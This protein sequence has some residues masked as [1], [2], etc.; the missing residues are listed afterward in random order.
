MVSGEIQLSL[1][2][3]REAVSCERARDPARTRRRWMMTLC[4][5]ALAYAAAV[6][7]LSV[8]SAD[9]GLFSYRGGPILSIEPD[10]PAAA[11]GLAVGDR[12][13]S[14]DGRAL[15]GPRE[16]ASALGGVVPGQTIRLGVAGPG[17]PA[18]IVVV[19]AARRMPWTSIAASVF[20]GFI[21]FLA[22]LADRGG[23]SS[24]P[25]QFFR[26]GLSISILLVGAFSWQVT[27]SHAALAMPWLI[28]LAMTPAVVCQFMMSHPVG[29]ERWARRQLAALY[30]PALVL[31]ALLGGFEL[32]LA[33]GARIP[34]HDRVL[35][36]LGGAAALTGAGYLS[37]GA[38]SRM[39]RVRR[40]RDRIARSAVRW[41]LASSICASVPI[42]VAFAWA[43]ID[44]PTLVGGAFRPL[45]AMAVVGGCT[46]AAMALVDV[47][48][49]EI[50]R[51]L[52]RRTGYVL[53][54]G[55][56]AGLF[57]I[58]VA[59][60]GGLVS[61]LSGGSF[62][63]ALAATFVA[64]FLFGPV[65]ERVQRTVDDRFGRDRERA[66][67]LLREAADAA[68]AT[69]DA[70]ELGERVVSRVRDAMSAEGAAIVA[71][72]GEGTWQRLAIGGAVPIG[73]PLPHGEPIAERLDRLATVGAPGTLCAD[74]LAVP[75][76]V[77]GA[78]AHALVVS[79]RAGG[80]LGSEDR[81]LLGTLA[82][83]L[84]AALANAHAHEALARMRDEAERRR[85]EI[86]RLKDL[87][88][89]ENRRLLR[90]L[91]SHGQ[92]EVIVGS[93]L[94]AT[95][96][97]VRRAART[98]S[99]VLV[100]GE[101]GCGKEVVAR[102]L[103][104]A[105]SRS[106]G[107]FIVV[108]CGALAP[109]LAESTLFGH[110]RGAFTGAVA[111][112]P[113]A[114]RAADGGTIFL[115]EL[116]EL[117]LALQPA[118]LRVL[119]EREVHPIGAAAGVR[120]DVRVVAGTH[121]DLAA[122]VATGRFRED[123]WYRLRVV[124]IDVPALRERRDDILPLAE[125]FLSR[126]AERAG[127][128]RKRLSAAARVALLEHDW[129]GN[130]RE[131]EHAIEAATVYAADEEILAAHLPIHDRIL[132]CRG[133]RRLKGANTQEGLREALDGLERERVLE[134][135]REQGGNRSRAARALGI[136]R[137]A[138]LR[139]LSRYGMA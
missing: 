84:G 64:A 98:D 77:D 16:V 52:R 22:L 14:M 37:I 17:E 62:S 24:A 103:H 5:V 73:D 125:H 99:T 96:D 90:E 100:S 1:P 131:L 112:A 78:G 111:D 86:A 119:Q 133:R 11:A 8:R 32:L 114:F 28:A 15:P 58:L 33:L 129:P 59:A 34:G 127:R 82:A 85:Q 63:A 124:E 138:L 102:A 113:G 3:V 132:R 95:F 88:E 109:G 136:S 110:E 104:A 117:P 87:V 39:Q 65:R 72:D 66:R 79:P 94:R 108:D 115:D 54:S 50:D 135:L 7:G 48:I 105:S 89:A 40:H 130:V 19:E 6:L 121:C 101:T 23:P 67:R 83:Q 61:V 134:V 60:A 57:L 118:L 106:S 30:G 36:L 107:P 2:E 47:P 74:I 71:R 68:L 69:L 55:L 45:V 75:I 9:L 12:I 97:M 4:A 76:E 81:E 10:G 116:G 18:R 53:A 120:V 31:A 21:L 41:F 44:L 13:V 91:A 137:G 80:E 92:R 38:I 42:L 49:G 20:A 29:R 128:P 25:R 27:M 93:G 70:R 126:A 123:L 46:G 122:L 26:Q 139:R 43:L 56:A 35:L 51:V